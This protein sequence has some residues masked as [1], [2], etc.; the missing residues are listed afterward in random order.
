MNKL[1]H[2]HAISRSQFFLAKA[3][4]CKASQRADFEA[5]IEASIIFARAA[6]HRIK[7]KYEKHPNW[8]A[9]WDGLFS[10]PSIIFFM[11]ERNW[12]L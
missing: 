7:T 6:I 12:I 1:D 9:W 2:R 10:Y 4:E 8:K 11:D 5:Y 3:K